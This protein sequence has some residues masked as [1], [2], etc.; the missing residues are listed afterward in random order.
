MMTEIGINPN[1][2]QAT[3]VTI[4][5]GYFGL[6]RDGVQFM[7]QPVVF[8]YTEVEIIA[9]VPTKE[10][11]RLQDNLQ[12]TDTKQLLKPWLFKPGKSGNPYGRPKGK[13][14]KTPLTD[15]MKEVA[16]SKHYEVKGSDEKVLA[17]E[18]M[19][20]QII[21]QAVKGDKKSLD[22]FLERI[23]GKVT[24]G[25]RLSGGLSH[26]TPTDDEMAKLREIFPDVK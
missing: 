8:K 11:E 7:D 20:E 25:I 12:K 3:V 26:G 18:I 17:I 10:I 1:T 9:C 21:D 14:S 2:R 4:R 24:Q 5:P 6:N 22:T 23:E 15:L 16:F 13:T 19:A